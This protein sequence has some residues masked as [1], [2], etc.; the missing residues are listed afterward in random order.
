MQ[1]ADSKASAATNMYRIQRTLS[2]AC[3]LNGA[4]RPHM[5]VLGK[6]RLLPNAA[7]II[8]QGVTDCMSQANTL[9]P[10]C[11]G[12]VSLIRRKDC[13]FDFAGTVSPSL[14]LVAQCSTFLHAVLL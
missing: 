10:G 2:S 4:T 1:L 5:A 6:A 13:L 11:L 9:G 3:T 14:T 8:W 12:D 7:R